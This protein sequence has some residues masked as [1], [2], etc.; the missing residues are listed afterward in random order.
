ML[1][2][3]D[4]LFT[5]GVFRSSCCGGFPSECFG[6]PL[7][8]YI[9]FY[10]MGGSPSFSSG[11][12]HFLSSSQHPSFLLFSAVSSSL[13]ELFPSLCSALLSSLT[14]SFLPSLQYPSFFSPVQHLSFLVLP[15]LL[16]CS[17]VFFFSYL[18]MEYRICLKKC[19]GCRAAGGTLRIRRSQENI[20]GSGENRNP[21]SQWPS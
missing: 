13:T 8:S 6:L 17:A 1:E 20:T 3:L 21:T 16:P 10:C 18:L 7:S 12:V 11:V 19:D 2:T 5:N 15:S 14:E 9:F 4:P